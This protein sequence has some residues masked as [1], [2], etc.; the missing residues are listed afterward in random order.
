MIEKAIGEWEKIYAKKPTFKDVAEKLSAYQDLRVD[1]RIKDYVTSG[2]PQFVT[3]CQ[4]L[5]ATMGFSV[6][7]TTELPN[8]T[9][10]IIAIENESEKWRAVK[11]MP[12]VLL[13]YRTSEPIDEPPLRD[14]LEE[15]RKLGANKCYVVTN[16]AFTRAAIAFAETR[17]Y[18]LVGKDQLQALL[19][20]T[21]G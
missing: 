19:K 6:Q 4:N 5:V 9:V 17:P 16:T 20:R 18:E 7:D 3:L 21:E 15:I 12:K 13:F 1:D 10:K 14:V 2:K 8:G 11:K